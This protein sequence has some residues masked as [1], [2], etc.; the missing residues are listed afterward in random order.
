M[1]IS[2][3]FFRVSRI[4]APISQSKFFLFFSRFSL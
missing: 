3:P 4:I 2:A 1:K